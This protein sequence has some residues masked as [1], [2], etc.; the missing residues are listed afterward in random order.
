MLLSPFLTSSSSPI[1]VYFLV[2][3]RVLFQFLTDVIILPFLPALTSTFS[4]LPSFPFFFFLGIF[5][6]LS[7]SAGDGN[8]NQTVPIIQGCF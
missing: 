4:L 5:Y 1:F 8:K 3:I 7:S 2:S 6:L